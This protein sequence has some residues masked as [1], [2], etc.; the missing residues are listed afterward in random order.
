MATWVYSMD[1]IM[2]LTGDLRKM[3]GD[4]ENV[5]TTHKE[6]SPSRIRRDGI[7]RQ[8]LRAALE[9]RI[10]PMDPVTHV[11]GCLLNI[12]NGQRAKPDVNVDRALE[13]GSEQL[14]QFEASWSEGF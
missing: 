2:T 3:S 13:V 10:D 14:T 11:A 12:S 7:D 5:Q 4:D 1:A 8:S 6:E 9:S